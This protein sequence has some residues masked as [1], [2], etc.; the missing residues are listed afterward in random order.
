MRTLPVRV[1]AAGR[2]TGDINQILHRESETSEATDVKQA[3]WVPIVP[4]TQSENVY[5]WAC[6]GG[7]AHS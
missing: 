5:Q 7:K 2:H 6:A 3:V 4:G 1:A